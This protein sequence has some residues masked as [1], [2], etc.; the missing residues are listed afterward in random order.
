M[1][2]SDRTPPI[3]RLPDV[4]VVAIGRNEGARLEACLRSVIDE[5]AAVVYVDSGSTDA[6]VA[7]ARNMGV[8]IVELD[9]H[10]PFTAARARNAGFEK[11]LER[12]PDI[13]FVQF[14]DGDCE[15]Q[16]GWL[17]EGRRQLI[18]RARTAAVA[19]RV[20]ERFPDRTIYNCLIDEE[21]DIA[22][23]DVKSCGGIVMMRAA[24]LREAGGYR[25]SLIAGEEPELCVRLRQ[26]GWNILCVAHAMT[27]HDAAMTKFSQ[28]WRRAMRCGYAFA[29]G[30]YL[31]G[32]PPERHWVGETR[33]I[34][35]W[36]AVIPVTILMSSILAGPA[37]LLL[38]LVYPAQVMR[39]Y[40]KRRSWSR[41]PFLGAV[42]LVLGKF[43][44]LAGQLRFLWNLQR[45]KTGRLIEYK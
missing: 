31:H 36:A 3:A 10:I 23:G 17:Q 9:L 40:L 27:L 6:S 12:I 5:A 38:A 14:V 4:A 21:L 22:P 16:A 32:A 41:T 35:L 18:E 29:E 25:A 8:E 2:V 44:E 19:G 34:W 13:A 7:M 39:L 45:G 20:K 43:P 11:L 33:S 24:A 26:R 42:F 30:A 1:T 15:M 28:W 37:A